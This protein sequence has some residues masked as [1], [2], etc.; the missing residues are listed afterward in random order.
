MA[1][2]FKTGDIVRLNS[3]GPDMT[4]KD[5]RTTYGDY[6]CQWFA[7]KKLEQGQFR[8]DSLQLADEQAE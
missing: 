8:E 6:S 4:V 2:K 3:G 5:Y 1:G 7:G